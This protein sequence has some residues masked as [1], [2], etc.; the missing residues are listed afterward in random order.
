[1][2]EL[3]GRTPEAT[4][5]LT[6][7]AGPLPGTELDDLQYLEHNSICSRKNPFKN[8]YLVATGDALAEVV[9]VVPLGFA[10][11]RVASRTS[12]NFSINYK[13]ENV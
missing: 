6:K 12:L 13:R 2:T 8:S 7:S 5:T 4:A 1:L 9:G 3:L 11:V 10:E